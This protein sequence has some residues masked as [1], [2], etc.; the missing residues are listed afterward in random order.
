MNVQQLA[1][2]WDTA[3]ETKPIEGLGWYESHPEPSLQLITEAGLEN[4]TLFIPGAGA[5]I[6]VDQ[7]VQAPVEIYANDI[8]TK[9]LEMLSNRVGKQANLHF[10][11]GDLRDE[12]TFNHLPPVDIWHDRAVFH[13]LTKDEERQAYLKNLDDNLTSDGVVHIATF[14]TTG[15]EKCSGLDVERYDEQKLRET[16]AP[17]FKLISSFE[18]LYHNPAGA[19]RPYI[20]ATFKRK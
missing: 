16:F 4:K 6:L 19:P 13:F 11:A 17:R 14:H 18:H 15:A 12:A 3:Y 2:H 9:A 10:L 8:S 20:Y 5:T 1:K 7:I